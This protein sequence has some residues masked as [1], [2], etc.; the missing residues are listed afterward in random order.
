MV[1][2]DIAVLG[3][4]GSV[5]RQALEVISAFPE[6]FRVVALAANRNASAM[7]E[8]VT[9]HHPRVVALADPLAAEDLRLRLAD[10]PVEVVSGA[11]NITSIGSDPD[12]D[13]IVAAMVGGAGLDPVLEAVR[14]GKTVALANK[15]TLV[16][17]GRLVMSEARAH[18]AVI[19]PVDSEHAAA[20]QL[21]AGVKREQVGKLILTASGGPFFGRSREELER[22]K[23]QEALAHPN[24]NMGAKVSIDSASMMNKGFE[25]IEAHWLFDLPAERIG[26]L[27]HPQSRVHAMLEMVDGSLL[28]QLARPDMR[29]SIAHALGFPELLDLPGKLPGARAPELTGMPG[30]AFYPAGEKDFPALGLCRQAL[31]GGGSLPAVLSV[32]DEITVAA[33][34]EGRIGFTSIIE[35]LARVLDQAHDSPAET[36]D[37]IKRAGRQ[38]AELAKKICAEYGK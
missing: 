11:D 17:A 12:V 23:P 8:L 38:G 13:M 21:L 7:A 5:G 33:F 28:M 27:V 30:L 10:D 29:L 9:R 1:R 6:R 14:A 36:L 16:M 15:E 4:T 34:L 31:E 3:A 18:G 26:V 22:V 37:D 19:L 25:I 2:Q 32:A 35:I 24:W 20:H